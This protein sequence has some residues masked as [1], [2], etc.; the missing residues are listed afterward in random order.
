MNEREQKTPL[1]LTYLKALNLF[2]FLALVI[3][4]NQF[5]SFCLTGLPSS[6]RQ[7]WLTDPARAEL[8]QLPSP[9]SIV[10]CTQKDVSACFVSTV[11]KHLKACK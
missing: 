9:I 10:G 5:A 4:G 2:F 8:C 3:T 1:I 6:F 7:P 11:V